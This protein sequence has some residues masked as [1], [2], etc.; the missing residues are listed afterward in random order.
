MLTRKATFLLF[1]ST[2]ALLVAVGG[3][4][5]HSRTPSHKPGTRVL[6]ISVKPDANAKTAAGSG[7]G[8]GVGNGGANGGPSGTFS[9]SGTLSGVIPGQP[10]VNFPI[11]ITNPNPWPIQV[12]SVTPTVSSSASATCS[13]QWLTVTGYTYRSGSTAITVAAKSTGS[14]NLT[15]KFADSTSD[16][17]T[18]CMDAPYTVSLAGNAQMVARP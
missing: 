18:S 8:N 1:S 6:A 16:D 14:M 2:L 13:T 7:G 10:A 11:T 17:Q 15:A 12:L 5:L 3:W 9:L 4:Q